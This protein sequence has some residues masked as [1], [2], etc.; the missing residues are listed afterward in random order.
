MNL[1][2]FLAQWHEF[3]P[4]S[5]YRKGQRFFNC[6]HEANPSLANKLRG[7][8]IDPFH[9]DEM[10]RNAIEFVVKNWY[11]DLDV[12]TIA[13]NVDEMEQIRESLRKGNIP[14]AIRQFRFLRDCDLRTAKNSVMKMKEEMK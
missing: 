14:A 7:Q 13:E 3:E 2:D 12:L 1:W 11:Q 6:L 10:L 8:S 9:R 4:E 5:D